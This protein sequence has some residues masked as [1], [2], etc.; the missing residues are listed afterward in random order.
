MQSLAKCADLLGRRV[1][2]NP[3]RINEREQVDEIVVMVFDRRAGQGP[4]STRD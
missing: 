3:T 2:R 4:A 1:L